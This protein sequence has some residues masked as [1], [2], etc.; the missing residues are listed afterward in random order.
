[1]K[2]GKTLLQRV[3]SRISKRRDMIAEVETAVTYYYEVK[4]QFG[5]GTMNELRLKQHK[6]NIRTGAESQKLDKELYQMLLQQDRMQ[7]AWLD[8]S[9][10]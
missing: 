3:Q 10:Q 4:E 5:F 2:T 1:M 7:A 9:F 8:G 6:A